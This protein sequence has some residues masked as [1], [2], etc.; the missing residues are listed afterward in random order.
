MQGAEEVLFFSLQNLR[1][2]EIATIV[3]LCMTFILNS[4]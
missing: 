2:L 1:K 4:F 3:A